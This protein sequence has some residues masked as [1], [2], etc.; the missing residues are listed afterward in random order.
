MHLLIFGCNYYMVKLQI[1]LF[2]ENCL[3]DQLL[4]INSNSST[5]Q[6]TILEAKLLHLQQTNHFYKEELIEIIFGKMTQA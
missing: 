2:N 4:S 5:N 1:D 6:V 3:Q